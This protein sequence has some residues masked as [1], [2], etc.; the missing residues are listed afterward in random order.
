MAGLSP[1]EEPSAERLA[2]LADLVEDDGVTTVFTEAL[3]SPRIAETLAREAGI[4]TAVLNPLEGLTDD[5]MDAGAGYESVMR[6]NLTALQQAL[7][8]ETTA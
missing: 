4:D 1:D 7:G 2:E 3:V 6:D 5:E 8:C